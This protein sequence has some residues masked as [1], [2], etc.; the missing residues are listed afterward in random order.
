MD[1]DGHGNPQRLNEENSYFAK[2]KKKVRA[3]YH[4]EV[5]KY[6]E[7]EKLELQNSAIRGLLRACVLNEVQEDREK[8]VQCAQTIVS[9]HDRLDRS[10]LTA[11]TEILNHRDGKRDIRRM[12]E[13]HECGLLAVFKKYSRPPPL[14]TSLLVSKRSKLSRDCFLDLLVEYEVVPNFVS[15]FTAYN[16]A[17][18]EELTFEDFC[19]SLS[20]IATIGLTREPFSKLYADECNLLR[21]LLE[22]WK[23]SDPNIT[24]RDHE[25]DDKCSEIGPR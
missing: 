15:R 4:A 13:K 21:A 14:S 22:T 25:S 3:K 7:R 2:L 5:V 24:G 1:I 19:T 8:H 17:M 9:Q 10:T 11:S 6:L 16:C 12:W 23:L 20:C 18:V